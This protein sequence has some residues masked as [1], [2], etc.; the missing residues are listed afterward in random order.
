MKPNDVLILGRATDTVL[1]FRP[2]NA[3]AKQW[4]DRNVPNPRTFMNRDLVVESRYAPDLAAG[5]AAG[6][7]RLTT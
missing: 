1:L 4:M 2:L 6:G 5:M 7:L 3:K